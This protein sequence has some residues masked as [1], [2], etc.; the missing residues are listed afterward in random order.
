M[1]AGCL[2]GADDVGR[3]AFGEPVD[4]RVVQPRP[5]LKGDPANEGRYGNFPVIQDP[6]GGRE[7]SSWC[8][9]FGRSYHSWRRTAEDGRS[10]G[11]AGRSTGHDSG[12]KGVAVGHIRALWRTCKTLPLAVVRALRADLQ[13][14]VIGV[15]GVGEEAMLPNVNGRRKLPSARCRAGTDPGTQR[16]PIGTGVDI[17]TGDQVMAGAA[18]CRR[19]R[20]PYSRL[21]A[22]CRDSSSRW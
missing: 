6:L 21:A 10:C 7:V 3:G 19:H 13:R 20:W 2:A 18:H 17:F 12:H 15:V 9:S 8:P 22:G 4:L 1:R 5:G 11:S 16:A 14:V